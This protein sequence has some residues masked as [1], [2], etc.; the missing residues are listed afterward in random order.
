MLVPYYAQSTAEPT[1]FLHHTTSPQAPGRSPHFTH[2]P[3]EWGVPEQCRQ[4]PGS[5]LPQHL[6]C[7]QE[8]RHKNF[9]VVFIFLY[10]GTSKLTVQPHS[11]CPKGKGIAGLPPSCPRPEACRSPKRSTSQSARA[12]FHALAAPVHFWA[13]WELQSQGGVHPHRTTPAPP[14]PPVCTRP[15]QV[16]LCPLP[17]WF[18]GAP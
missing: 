12:I 11:A 6:S 14:H 16:F 2:F 7:N 1:Q 4:G 18:T 8:P 17:P 9:S 5:S 3:S 15:S 10:S 13:H